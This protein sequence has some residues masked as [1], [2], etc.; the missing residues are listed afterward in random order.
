MRSSRLIAPTRR[1]SGFSSTITIEPTAWADIRCA[2]SRTVVPD[3]AVTT[4]DS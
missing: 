2:S 4:L 1:S 3:V